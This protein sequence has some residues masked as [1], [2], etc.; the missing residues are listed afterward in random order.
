MLKVLH[1]GPEDL[2][3]LPSRWKGV[4]QHFVALANA[5]GYKMGDLIQHYG[6]AVRALATSV[7]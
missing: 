7:L 1:L 2:E 3:I 5:T 4:P 6:A